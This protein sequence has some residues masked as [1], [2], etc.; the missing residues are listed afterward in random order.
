LLESHGGKDRVRESA[1][2]LALDFAR[3]LE[4]ERNELEVEAIRYREQEAERDQQADERS[5]LSAERLN[6]DSLRSMLE[7]VNNGLATNGDNVSDWRSDMESIRDVI[8]TTL[9]QSASNAEKQIDFVCL[10]EPRCSAPC[11]GRNC[12]VAFA[13]SHAATKAAPMPTT[14]DYEAALRQEYGGTATADTLIDLWMRDRRELEGAA[15]SSTATNAAPQAGV[16]SMAGPAAQYGEPA[17]AAWRYRPKGFSTGWQFSE[18]TPQGLNERSHGFQWD[19]EPLYLSAPSA[20]GCNDIEAVAWAYRKLQ[21]FGVHQGTMDSA[22]MMDRLKLL[23]CTPERG[24]A[25]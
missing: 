9:A 23:L 2:W 15:R 7:F 12:H 1:Y 24:A 17:V 14:D 13:R 21:T 4:R 18:Y 16:R 19:I 22:L 20:T 3:L 11:G 6:H 8:E 25:S 5:A 10:K